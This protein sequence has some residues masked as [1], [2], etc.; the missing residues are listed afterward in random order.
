MERPRLLLAD[1]SA[2]I[3]R[4]VNLTFAD[5][6]F[7]V[8]SVGDGDAAVSEIAAARP[9]IV[10][11]DV[12]MPGPSGYEICSMLRGIEETADTPVILLVG[13]F[14]QFDPEEAERAGADAFITKPFQSIRQ[15]VD[16]VKELVS[17]K[18][19]T[20]VPVVEATPTVEPQ[21]VQTEKDTSDIDSLYAQ[22]FAETIEMRPEI[23]GET[24]AS[25]FITDQLDD[26]MI[27]TSFT[28]ERE[29]DLEQTFVS[30]AADPQASTNYASQPENLGDV[31][32]VSEFAAS[33][34]PQ[35]SPYEETVRMDAPP[36]DVSAAAPHTPHTAP[37]EELRRDPFAT[38]TDAFDLN[39]L[40]L[41]DLTASQVEE[42][43]TL[44]TPTQSVESGSSKQVVTIS[45]ELMDIIVSKVVEKLSEKY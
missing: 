6:G 22:S 8:V 15:V 21:A 40:D 35:I 13:S 42:Q 24:D 1:D 20:P 32:R 5:E 41:L 18:Q 16:Q 28:G 44:G 36:L 34:E 11:A 25:A 39:D 45:P 12:H 2:T 9:D 10:L 7:D 3:Q 26:E 31:E 33:D 17:R 14:E 43:F 29:P 23:A 30:E 4:V 27:E 37:T 19:K 38:T